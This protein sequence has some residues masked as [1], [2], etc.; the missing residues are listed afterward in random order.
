M[1]A[2]DKI[3]I[4][5][6]I[7]PTLK[8][9][10][11]AVPKPFIGQISTL[12]RNAIASWLNLSPQP[13]IIL[14]GNDEGVREVA[15]E[16]GVKHI[17]NVRCTPQGTPL[18][19]DIFAQVHQIATHPILAYVNADIIL[20]ND[21]L[22]TVQ[23]VG[24]KEPKFLILGRRWNLDIN[25]SINFTTSEVEKQLRDRLQQTAIFGGI[26]ALD[27]FVFPKPLFSK[28]PE[29][30]VGRAG[31][32]NWMVGE[33]LKQNYPVINASR[34]ITAVHQ[35]HDYRH[36]KG[37]RQE[38]FHGGEAQQ[39]K[40]L[41]RG[42]FAGNSADATCYLTFQTPSEN[43]RVSL[44]IIPGLNHS[45]NLQNT[46]ESIENK[47]HQN[48][49]IIVFN[50][51]QKP[52]NS[53]NIRQIP[54][55]FSNPVDAYNTGLNLAQG[56][57]ILFLNEGCLLKP[58]AIYEYING[59]EEQAGS[60]EMVFSGWETSNTSIQPSPILSPVLKGSQGL[61]G[62]HIWML[63]NLWLL[64]HPSSVMFERNSL[65]RCGEF[66]TN[67]SPTAAIL[68][69]VLHLS[70]RGF[71]GICL[72]N[73][74][75]CCPI[76]EENI[77]QKIDDCEY[78]LNRFF[79]RPHLPHWMQPLKP[80]AH[81]NCWVWLAFLAYQS[82]EFE[83]MIELLKRSLSYSSY[84]T[85]ETLSNWIERFTRISQEYNSQFDPNTLN[86]LPIWKQF[87]K[88]LNSPEIKISF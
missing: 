11:F 87:L 69:R 10:L 49:E 6:Q 72:E 34:V 88:T 77:A 68:D 70:S 35:N 80:K 17:P 81:Y 73:I 37:Q 39:N 63:P 4:N 26:G 27:Y 18:L 14:F 16:F 74:G 40:A 75:V 83:Q 82:G 52:I 71:A 67:L 36:L 1:N 54:Q 55:S 60:V 58:D 15:Q 22:P 29:F 23:Q 85:A 41:S 66:D 62:L 28:L 59:F 48:P 46:V 51:I 45:E 84:S 5:P 19:N 53:N 20:L 57:F 38:A 78:I 24:S 56:E 79:E 21:F 9:T 32:D 64:L 65:K 44:V 31:W 8:I 50:E 33:A 7:Q 86:N 2:S 42:T 76:L 13:E 43:P 25:H 12:Q 61:H 3:A 47:T 30:A